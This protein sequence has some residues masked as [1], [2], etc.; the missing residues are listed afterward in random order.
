MPVRLLVTVVLLLTGCAARER[1]IPAG[2]V[3]VADTTG[4]KGPDVYSLCDDKGNL[5]Y[6]SKDKNGPVYAIKDGCKPKPPDPPVTPL[7]AATLAAPPALQVPQPFRVELVPAPP[8]PSRG[9]ALEL[10]RE[11][12]VQLFQWKLDPN[13]AAADDLERL[14]GVTVQDAQAILRGRPYRTLRD[15]VDKRVLTEAQLHAVA[16]YLMIR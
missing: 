9:A 1:Q 5:I 7:P 16:P 4:G 12:V 10:P 11:F 13:T 15:L 3:V 14:P 8:E 2:A 6:L